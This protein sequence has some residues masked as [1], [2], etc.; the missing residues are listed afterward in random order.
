MSLLQVESMTLAQ[1]RM[2]A[3]IHETAVDDVEAL[4][5]R[6][7]AAE[8]EAASAVASA[9]QVDVSMDG[10]EEGDEGARKR[11]E[12]DEERARELERAQAIQASASSGGTMKIRTDYVPKRTCYSTGQVSFARLTTLIQSVRRATRQ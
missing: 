6:Q 1:K 2:A 4:R 3:M 10:G 9:G 12:E 5:A 8:A 7:A 11:R